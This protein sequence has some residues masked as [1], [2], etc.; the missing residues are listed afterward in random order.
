M[1][2]ENNDINQEEGMNWGS[3]L[4]YLR[5]SNTQGKSVLG[6]HQLVSPPVRQ[7]F[8]SPRADPIAL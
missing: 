6:P 5:I 8:D 3:G 4:M 1:E 7:S 2:K